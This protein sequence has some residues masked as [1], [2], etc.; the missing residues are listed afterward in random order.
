MT[1]QID[2]AD[3]LGSEYALTPA[4]KRRLHGG[5]HKPPVKRGYA[6][7]PG[8]GPK[9]ETCKTCEHIFRN[10]LA[11][12]YLK[13]ELA[14]ARW[15]GGGGSDILAGSPACKAWEAKTPE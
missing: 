9:G 10:R 11:K 5:K 4:E 2:I 8:T 12:T 1:R 6:Y 14:K 13:C 3:I 7:P 15:T